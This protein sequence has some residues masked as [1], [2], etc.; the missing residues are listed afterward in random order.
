MLRILRQ[1]RDFPNTTAIVHCSAGVGRTGTMVACEICLKILL[2]G[3][4]LSVRF[5]LINSQGHDT[6]RLTSVV[7]PAD[8][9]TDCWN[10]DIF[11]C[12]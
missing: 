10:G 9:P 7:G 8:I 6:F 1:V 11:N 5:Y 2:E 12:C 3:K 4:E